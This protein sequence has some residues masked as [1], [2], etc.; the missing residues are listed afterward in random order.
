M[1]RRNFTVALAA[2]AGASATSRL[3]AQRGPLPP[4]KPRGIRIGHTGLTWPA[5]PDRHGIEQAIKDIGAL[6][7]HGFETFAETLDIYEKEGGLAKHLEAAGLPLI[8]AYCSFD[9]TDPAKRK[10]SLDK[11]VAWGKVIR[12]NGGKVAVLGPNGVKRGE[13]SF[14]EHKKDI[15]ASLNEV[16]KALMDIGVTGVVHPHTGTCIESLDEAY[17]VME[18]VDTRYVK[19]GPDVGQ[20]VKGGAEPAAVTKMVKDFAS[21]VHHMHLKDYSG[22]QFYIGYCPLGFGR[23][24]IANILDVLEGREL[25]GM[26]LV[27]LDGGRVTPMPA[28]EAARV[29][30]IFLQSIGASFR[31]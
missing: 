28:G 13:Y 2:G 11:M 12:K 3:L 16:G 1:N 22:G 6:G 21:I 18:A 19:F 26:V 23:V 31:A 4:P 27:E 20:L 8:S 10:E 17:G 7:Y 25:L 24:E 5:G 15:V 29:S 14:G 9:M 30:K